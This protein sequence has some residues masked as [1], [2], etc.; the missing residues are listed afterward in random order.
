MKTIANPASDDEIVSVTLSMKHIRLLDK[1]VDE[2]LSEA[3]MGTTYH[4]EKSLQS[5]ADVFFNLTRIK[6][7]PEQEAA[8]L[9]AWAQQSMAE[10]EARLKAIKGVAA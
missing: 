8:S 4:C 2:E 7:S 9:K 10:D 5:L 1:L 6:L 3:E